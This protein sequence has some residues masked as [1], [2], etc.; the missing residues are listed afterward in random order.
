MEIHISDVTDADLEAVLALNQSE[1][2]HV[3]S[4]DL[5]RMQWFAEHADYFR[6]ARSGDQL[7]GFLIGIL[8]GSDYDSLNYRWFDE[9]GGDFAYVDRIAVAP[10]ARRQGL[11]SRFY[12]DFSSAVTAKTLTCEVNIEPPNPQ[13]MDFHFRLGFEQVGTL[14]E[15]GDKQVA[16]LRKTL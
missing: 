7:A 13:S 4:V 5:V 6:V 15:P 2:P 3:G 14:G 10:I 9:R 11:A 1:V 16:L 8:P 12:N